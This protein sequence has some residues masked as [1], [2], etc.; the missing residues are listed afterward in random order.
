MEVMDMEDKDLT[1]K[2]SDEDKKDLAR[3]IIS[4]YDRK[5]GGDFSKLKLRRF[6][7]DS[8]QLFS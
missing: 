6:R 5:F 4:L 2:L 1:S 3:K 7:R 8:C